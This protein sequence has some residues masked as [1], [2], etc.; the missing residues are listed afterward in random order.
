M[1]VIRILADGERELP[2]R[3]EG[4][5]VKLERIYRKKGETLQICCRVWQ[6]EK[7]AADNWK[8]KEK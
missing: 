7:G 5:T 8:K 3:Q 6:Q 1:E 2:F 4:T